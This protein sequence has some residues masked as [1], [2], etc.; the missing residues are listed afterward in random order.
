MRTSGDTS[1]SSASYGD[2]TEP[3]LAALLPHIDGL[4]PGFVALKVDYIAHS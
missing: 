1:H 3:E 2:Q 4:P